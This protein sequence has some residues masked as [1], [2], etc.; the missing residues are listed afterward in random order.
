M[1]NEA[2]TVTAR[3]LGHASLAVLNGFQI[4]KELGLTNLKDLRVLIW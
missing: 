4:G 1:K 3:R 2:A